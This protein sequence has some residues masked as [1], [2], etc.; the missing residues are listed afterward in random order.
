MENNNNIEETEKM[1]RPCQDKSNMIEGSIVAGQQRVYSLGDKVSNL[2]SG[3]KDMIKENYVDNIEYLRRKEICRKCPHRIDV[4]SGKWNEDRVSKSDKCTACDCF[5]I[6]RMGK[7]RGK[8][9]LRNQD[10][11]LGKWK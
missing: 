4:I 10:C 5:L 2:V 7:I 8:C 1:C 9:W 3:V 11:P 6:T